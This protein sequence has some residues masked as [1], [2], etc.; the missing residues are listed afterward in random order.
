MTHL[1]G[2]ELLSWRDAG[3]EADRARVV[4]HLAVC[5]ECGAAYAELIRTRPA[6]GSAGEVEAVAFRKAGYAARRSGLPAYRPVLLA[7]GLAA[8]A[9][10]G[11]F[12][13]A[14]AGS[15]PPT[16]QQAVRGTELV[17]LSPA[18]EVR[19][20]FEFRWASPVSASSYRVD[21]I[22][23]GGTTLHSIRTPIEAAAGP[24]LRALL[25]P[26]VR[27]VWT[28]TALTADGRTIM[29]SAA[30]PFVVSPGP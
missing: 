27:Y 26:G 7:A 21:V 20:P 18:G 15:P 23:P 28:V 19:A 11:V 17:P 12:L 16:D 24:E 29:T 22:E 14:R 4:G 25:R 8:V 10:A 13:L 3:E 6:T 1:T 9:A 30:Q 5:D 2:E